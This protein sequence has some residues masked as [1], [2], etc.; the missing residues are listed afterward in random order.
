MLKELLYMSPGPNKQD[1]PADKKNQQ[2]KDSAVK[3]DKKSSSSDEKNEEPKSKSYAEILKG[4][5]EIDK[6][7]KRDQQKS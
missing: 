3:K 1:D 2:V 4:F 6:I 7:F 5:E